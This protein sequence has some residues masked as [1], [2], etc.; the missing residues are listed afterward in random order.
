VIPMFCT[1]AGPLYHDISYATGLACYRITV[2]R[3]GSSLDPTT[4]QP[5]Y[6][7]LGHVYQY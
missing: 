3:A 5:E 2:V 7:L 1:A 4:V 6:W